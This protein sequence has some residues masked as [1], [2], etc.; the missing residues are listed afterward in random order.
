MKIVLVEERGGKPGPERT[1]AGA[2]VRV[3]RDPSEC[4][5]VFEQTQWPM[6]S[7]RH[8]EFNLQN[9]RCVPSDTNSSFGTYLNGEK[10]SHPAEIYAGAR[11]QFGG[12]G[13]TVVILKVEIDVPAIVAD[14]SHRPDLRPEHSREL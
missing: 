14:V 12:A 1:A 11:I 6:V 10:L 7:R 3:G 5:I 8:A 4:Q 9:G 13:P 2:S